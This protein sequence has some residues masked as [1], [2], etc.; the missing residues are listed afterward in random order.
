MPG[1]VR[2]HCQPD[3]A[4]PAEASDAW[5]QEDLAG[6]RF[7]D[8]WADGVYFKPR[9]GGD[10]QCMLVPTRADE[11]GRKEVLAIGMASARTRTA[12]GTFCAIG[13]PGP[14]GPRT[15]HR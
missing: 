5:R 15:D 2:R 11:E 12:G 1:A 10:R 14:C 4:G 3:E 13:G 6:R 8:V 9:Q 7:I